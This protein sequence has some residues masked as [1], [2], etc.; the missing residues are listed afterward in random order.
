VSASYSDHQPIKWERVD[1]YTIIADERKR[2]TKAIG[3]QPDNPH[4]QWM[5]RW[6]AE[7][8]EQ[9]F[10]KGDSCQ[11]CDTCGKVTRYV[12]R[13]EFSFCDEYGCGMDLCDEC[14]LKLARQVRAARKEA[15]HEAL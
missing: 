13:S 4:W 11:K 10:A 3:E 12:W 7:T 9:H 5:K 14:I 15:H 8:D 1:Q 6:L 2:L